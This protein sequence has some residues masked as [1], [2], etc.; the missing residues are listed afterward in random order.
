MRQSIPRV[1]ITTLVACALA[2]VASVLVV[3]AASSTPRQPNVP[4]FTYGSE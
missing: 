3:N 2:F 4:V 1:V